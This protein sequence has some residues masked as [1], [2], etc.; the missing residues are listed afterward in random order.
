[1][2][3][4]ASSLRTHA[5]LLPGKVR[6]SWS[7]PLTLRSSNACMS[8]GGLTGERE[9][10]SLRNCGSA[11]AVQ[12]S[13]SELHSLTHRS[14]S[15][16]GGLT[17]A[18]RGVQRQQACDAGKQPKLTTVLTQFLQE[19]IPGGTSVTASVQRIRRIWS[20]C[21]SSSGRDHERPGT[22]PQSRPPR[23]HALPNTRGIPTQ[24]RIR[25]RWNRPRRL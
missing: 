11:A 17:E 2:L 21:G 12:E 15:V 20:D 14:S 8:W 6:A 5:L 22:A 18:A 4:E 3:R 19:L 7:Q 23:V 1:L 16:G 10:S 13:R 9:A 24:N 25:V